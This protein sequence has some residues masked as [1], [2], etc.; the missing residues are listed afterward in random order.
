MKKNSLF[1][2]GLVTGI[3]FMLGG[4]IDLYNPPEISDASNY[5]VVDGFLNTSNEVSTIRLSRTT[6]L[7]E[8]RPPVPETGAK[9]TVEGDRISNFKFVEM[10]GGVY[11]LPPEYIGEQ[12]Q[13]RLKIETTDGNVYY[14][15]FT[16]ARYTPEIDSITYEVVNN[17]E[18]VQLNI[19]SKDPTGRTRFYRWEFDETWEY[20]AALTSPLML[21]GQSVVPRTEEIFR[22]WKSLSSS[23]I[24]IG[25]TIHLQHDILSNVGIATFPISSNRFLI[26]Y[27]ALVRQYAISKEAYEYWMALAKSTETTGS[28]FDPMPS[29]VTGNIHCETNAKELVF[30]FFSVGSSRQKRIFFEPRLGQYPTCQPIT[31]LYSLG[32]VLENGF[33]IVGQDSGKYVVAQKECVDCRIQGGVTRRPDFWE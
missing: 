1:R 22:C 9:V 26:K 11:T 23:K 32:E 7:S 24:A 21:V 2:V 14:S 30:G 16:N 29:L 8:T 12:E 6:H 28:I 33:L 5:L 20:T 27:S 13:Y 17:G 10:G 15:D 4:C 3:Q 18:A 31:G 19:N 25:S